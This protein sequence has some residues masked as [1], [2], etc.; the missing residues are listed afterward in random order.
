VEPLD[1]ER[2]CLRYAVAQIRD[3]RRVGA[4]LN[5][6]D[7]SSPYAR[8]R[9]GFQVERLDRFDKGE[10]AWQEILVEDRHAGPAEVAA[11]RLNFAAWLKLLPSRLRRIAK[12]LAMG[13]TTQ[14]ASKKF[15]V[16]PGRISQIR[17]ELSQGWHNFQGDELACV[18]A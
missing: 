2:Y 4:K 6:R 16:S 10:N 5:I 15:D 8:M 14:D 13:E 3:G 1:D 11:M 18:T 12:F 9:K 17:K 7:V